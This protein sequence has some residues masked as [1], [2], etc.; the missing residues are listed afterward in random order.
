MAHEIRVTAAFS[1]DTKPDKAPQVEVIYIEREVSGAKVAAFQKEGIPAL[2]TA[3]TARAAAQ[4]AQL[5]AEGG[6]SQRPEV[7]R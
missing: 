3:L 7:K 1:D 5:A 4:A 2:A 6:P